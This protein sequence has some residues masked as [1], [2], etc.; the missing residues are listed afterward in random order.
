MIVGLEGV[1]STSDARLVGYGRGDG[2]QALIVANPEAFF[3]EL[4]EDLILIGDEIAP[5]DVIDRRIDLLALDRQG[6]VVVIELKRGS[7]RLQ[8][9]Q[10]VSY[11]ALISDWTPQ[12]LVELIASKRKMTEADA[13]EQID[14]FLDCELSAVNESQRVVLLA[15]AYDYGVLAAGQWL[16]ERYGLDIRCYQMRLARQGEL[17][18][19]SCTRLF[20]ARDLRDQAVG[21]RKVTAGGT[22]TKWQDGDTAL[23][24]MPNEDERAF[25]ERQLAS[26]YEQYRPDGSLYFRHEGKRRWCL[27]ICNANRLTPSGGGGAS[28]ILRHATTGCAR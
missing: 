15:E 12:H 7:D 21:K 14:S 25:Y 26:D 9:L 11:A 22:T 19:L 1:A 2:L 28:K 4:G 27:T 10:A 5:S 3:M 17:T 8:L 6:S 23:A 20:P 16:T 18:P 13:T 24:A